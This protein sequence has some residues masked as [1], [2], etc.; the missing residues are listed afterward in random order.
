SIAILDTGVDSS[1]SDMQNFLYFR[2]FTTHGYPNGST[3]IDYGHHGTHC[4]SIAAGTG[5]ADI[6]PNTVEQTISL[7]FPPSTLSYYIT[8]WFEVKDN[9]NTPD[10]NVTLDWD[11]SGGGLAYFEIRDSVGTVISPSGPYSSSPISHNL[12]NLT[13]GWYQVVVVPAVAATCNK[14]YTITIEHESKYMI[15]TE[16][17]NSPVYTGVAPQSKI[18]SL[19]ILDDSGSGTDT[20]FHSAL[21]WISTNGKSPAYNI[22]VVSMSIGFDGI[23]SSIDTAINNLVDEGFVCVTSAG[24]DGTN[25]GDNAIYSPGTAQKCITVG[26][27]N[28][29]FE[30]TYYSSNGNNVYNKPDVVAPGGTIALSGSS[31]LHNLILAADSNYGEDY[32]SMSDIVA[33]DYIGMQGTSM[34]CPHVAGLAQLAID[35]IIRKEGNWIWSQENALRIKQIIC[36]GTWEVNAGETLDGDEDDIPQNPPLNRVGRDVVEGFGMVRADAVIQSI[37]NTTTGPFTNVPYY[38]DRRAGTYAKDAKVTLFSLDAVVGTTYLFTLTVPSTGDFDLI[39]YDDDYDSSSGSPVVEISSI[40]SG[41]DVDESLIFTPTESDT[42]Y[43]S[44]RAAQGYGTCEVSM[45]ENIA[46]NA[47]NNSSPIN[48]AT[49]INLNLTLS[50]DVFDPDGDSMDVSFYDASD[51][52]LIGTDLG[53]SSGGTASISWID[54]SAGTVYNWY[55]VAN[56]SITTTASST[57]SFTTNY[58]PNYPTNPTPI[59]GATGIGLSPTISVDVSDAD[60]DLMN[61]SFYDGS[62][63]SL[64]GVNNS[65]PSGGTASIIWFGLSEGITYSWYLVASDGLS[66]I[67]STTWSF[68]VFIDIPIW[69]QTPTDQSIEYDDS[70]IYDLNATDLSGIALYWVNDT[71]NFNIDGNG[72]LT[73]ITVLALGT[74]W[75]EVRAYDPYDNY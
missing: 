34:S 17:V 56:D 20:W 41:L 48:G 53:V 6:D 71:F 29:A 57:W 49:R 55:A 31:S 47:P 12:G 5:I 33:N 15:S 35:A 65:V 30:I 23:Y 70:F 25:F 24:N 50:V 43:W 64:I 63:D 73:N 16:P 69:E 75:L 40:S 62:D 7:Y 72:V 54:L 60:G 42:Y 1:H 44:I 9:L 13:S 38:L 67:T 36:M 26:A 19:K 68:T 8:H 61:V 28:D 11:I 37:T 51:D 52:S 18:V 27:V 66:S 3:G 4:A 59:H 46:P 21:N 14:D 32:N 10:T 45:S 39:I 2:D 22:T 74:Y 58:A